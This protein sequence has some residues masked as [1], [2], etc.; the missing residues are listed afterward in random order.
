MEGEREICSFM[1]S[2]VHYKEYILVFNL[3]KCNQSGE[4]VN[5]S[6]AFGTGVGNSNKSSV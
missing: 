6:M 4:N 3:Y 5:R 1:L 2:S